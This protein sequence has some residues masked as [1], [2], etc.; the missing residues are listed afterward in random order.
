MWPAEGAVALLQQKYA[1][2]EQVFRQFYAA[3]KGPESA[4]LLAQ[5][6]YKQGKVNEALAIYKEAYARKK[7]GAWPKTSPSS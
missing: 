3:D 6:L 1:E 2:A 4:S 5:T 7:T